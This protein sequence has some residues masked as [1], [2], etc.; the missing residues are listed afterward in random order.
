MNDLKEAVESTNRKI[1]SNEIPEGEKELF[2][3]DNKGE[4]ALFDNLMMEIG[5]DGKFQKRFNFIYN[6][7]FVILLTMPY[8]NIILIMTIPDH[9]C[10]VPGRETTNYTVDEWKEKWLPK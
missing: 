6:F 8:L 5:N 1:V 7:V 4:D 9:W 2:E 10:H 3:D